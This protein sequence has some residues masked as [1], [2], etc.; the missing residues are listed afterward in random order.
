MSN[1]RELAQRLRQSVQGCSI[2]LHGPVQAWLEIIESYKNGEVELSEIEK[3]ATEASQKRINDLKES[4]VSEDDPRIKKE[5]ITKEF[6]KKLL[7]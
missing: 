4:G 6:I 7:T 1:A 5:K 3:I 2:H